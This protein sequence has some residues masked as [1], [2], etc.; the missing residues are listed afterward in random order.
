MR[1]ARS[2]RYLAFLR[3]VSGARWTHKCLGSI[4]CAPRHA[5][6]LSITKILGLNQ[7]DFISSKFMSVL[8]SNAYNIFR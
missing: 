1:L 2:R 4:V 3:G 6:Q 5:F 8:F 7:I